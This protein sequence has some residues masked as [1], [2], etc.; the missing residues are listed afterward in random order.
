VRLAASRFGAE[1]A[2]LV[3]GWIFAGH[4]IGAAAAA[5]GAGWSRVTL[6]SYLPAFFTGG[7]LC[8]IAAV[9]IMTIRQQEKKIATTVPAAS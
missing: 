2:G 6:L 1:R 9:A 5:F 4:Q 8:L 3:F 7:A